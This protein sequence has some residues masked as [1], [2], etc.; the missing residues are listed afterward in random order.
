M[1]KAAHPQRDDDDGA[2]RRLHAANGPGGEDHDAAWESSTEEM[3]QTY[4]EVAGA[5]SALNPFPTSMTVPGPDGGPI[6][7]ELEVLDGVV[8]APRLND[9]GLA[10][11]VHQYVTQYCAA[12]SSSVLTEGKMDARWPEPPRRG[13]LVFRASQLHGMLG[14]A[15]DEQL[16]AVL[17]EKLSGAV[18]FV[19]ESPRLP[20]QVAWDVDPPIIGLPV[21]AWYEG[22]EAAR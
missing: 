22:S 18:R 6:T 8:Y 12:W 2:A 1:A 17:P 13:Q 5:G 20:R 15:A 10:P 16:V 3:K 9:L 21:A 11:Q 19:V 7:V 14:L 4:R